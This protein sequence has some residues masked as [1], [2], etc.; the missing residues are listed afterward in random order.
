MKT[1]ELKGCR[2][3]SERH[4][5]DHTK[6]KNMTIFSKIKYFSAFKCLMTKEEKCCALL[7]KRRHLDCVEL[8]PT[9]RLH[10]KM[11]Q[12]VSLFI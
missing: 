6:A 10:A 11:Y 8:K 5:V 7:N 12:D 1:E 2:Q 3:T 4:V 9:S